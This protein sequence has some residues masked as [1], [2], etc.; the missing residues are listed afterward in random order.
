ME[1]KLQVLIIGLVTVNTD[2]YLE[3]YRKETDL[4]EGIDPDPEELVAYVEE[5]LQEELSNGDAE[6]EDVEYISITRK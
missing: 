6:I 3:G 1:L 2:D 5:R 4:E